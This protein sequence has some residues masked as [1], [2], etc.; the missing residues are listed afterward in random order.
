MEQFWTIFWSAIGVILM[1]LATWVS[2]FV[3]SWLSSKIKDKKLQRLSLALNDIVTRAVMTVTQTYVESM[4][5]QNAF[6]GEAQ[7][8]AL[9]R[10]KEIVD[11]Q[12]TQ[13]LRDFVQENFKDVE[14]YITS[15]IESTILGL[16]K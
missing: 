9:R 11:A 10:C 13:E 6:D 3:T 7:K 5:K 12:L 2:T 4:K 8:E 15:L 14:S 1:G 16:K